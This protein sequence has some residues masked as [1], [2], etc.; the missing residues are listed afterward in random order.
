MKYDSTKY[1]FKQI[2]MNNKRIVVIGGGAAG[3]FGAI[4]AAQVNKGAEVILLEKNR[5][6]LNKVRISGGG[7][8]NIT[9]A[10]FDDK[11]LAKFYPRGGSFLRPLFKVFNPQATIDW[12]QQLGVSLKV[13]SDG[14]MFPTTD[15]S[16][17]IAS[18]L[19]NTAI[20]SGVQVR[21]SCGVESILPQKDHKLLLQLLDGSALLADSVL[22]TTGG[23]PSSRGYEWL[24]KLGLTIQEPVPSLFTFNTPEGQFKELSGI[25]VPQAQVRIAGR[26][27]K[28]DG[29]LLITHWG[30]SGPAILKLSAW[31]ARDLAE[32]DYEF[33]A[34]ISWGAENTENSV[35]EEFANQK[36]LHPKKVIQSNAMLGIPSRL[37]KKLCELSEID[38][39]LR[40]IDIANKQSNKLIENLINCPQKVQGKTTFKEEFVTCGGID[41]SEVNPETMESKKIKGLFFAGEV[42][43]IDAVTGGFNFQAAWTTG[44]VA[45]SNL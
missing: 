37:W 11:K 22:V 42:L 8:C 27:I 18:C 40:W 10:C 34:L 24:A 1:Q 15:D 17:T 3:F 26:K 25:S 4:R 43:D 20:K 35:R 5:T 23:N 19:E 16:E 32:S 36:K 9:H 28:Q 14:R 2:R 6:V 13:E 45:G 29:A 12:F 7:R 30:F 44:F 31:G 39:Q 41:L 21:T 33:T 38:E